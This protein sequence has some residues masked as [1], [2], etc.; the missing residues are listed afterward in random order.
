V[1]LTVEFPVR[2][3]KAPSPPTTALGVA[4]LEV[5]L[6]LVVVALLLP[7]TTDLALNVVEL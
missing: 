5:C 3:P 1:P 6:V 4:V 2:L 7:E